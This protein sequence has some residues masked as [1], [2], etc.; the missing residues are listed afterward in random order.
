MKRAYLYPFYPSP[1]QA[2]ELARTFGCGRKVDNLAHEEAGP[3]LVSGAA[4]SVLRGHFRAAHPVE[5]GPGPD[6]DLAYLSEVS[7]IPAQQG[8]RHLQTA[9]APFW[10]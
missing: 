2:Q 9:Y 8:L 7:C 5:E 10:A 1:D 6:P 4:E 3:R